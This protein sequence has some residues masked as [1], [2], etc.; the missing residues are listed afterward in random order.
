[1][2]T[3]PRAPP[4]GPWRQTR[5]DRAAQAGAGKVALLLAH[6]NITNGMYPGNDKAL[7]VANV[8]FKLGGSAAVLSTR[9]AGPPPMRRCGAAPGHANELLRALDSTLRDVHASV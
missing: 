7:L 1:L 5:A 6:E 2:L 3:Q 8:L 4:T 9:R